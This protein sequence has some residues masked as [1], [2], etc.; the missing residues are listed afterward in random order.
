MPLKVKST[1]LSN[2][3]TTTLRENKVE[4]LVLNFLLLGEL[5]LLPRRSGVP[6]GQG[7]SACAF[8]H[9]VRELQTSVLLGLQ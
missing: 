7:S 8:W 9:T 1:M 4:T 5:K 6:V 2:A 3:Q